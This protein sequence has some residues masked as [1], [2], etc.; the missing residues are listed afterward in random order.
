MEVDIHEAQTQLSQLIE[1]AEQGEDVVIAKAG[2][3]VVRISVIPPPVPV[4]GSARGTVIAQEGWDAP[5][6]DAEME[7]LF[8]E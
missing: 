1:L 6:T 2:K 3:P 7:E 5:L 8:G 4:L